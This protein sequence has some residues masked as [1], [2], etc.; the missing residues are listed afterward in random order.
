MLRLADITF[1]ANAEYADSTAMITAQQTSYIYLTQFRKTAE[2]RVIKHY[3]NSNFIIHTHKEFHFFKAN[4]RFGYFSFKALRYIKKIDADIILVE[5]LVFPLQVILLK[6]ALGRNVK[7]IA[8]HQ[9]ERPFKGIKKLLQVVADQCMNAYLFTSLGNAREWFEAGIIDDHSKIYE[10]PATL[11]GFSRL[12]KMQSRKKLN[13]GDG[14]QYLW[15]GRLN[16]NKDPLTVLLAFEQLLRANKEARLH[17][18]FQTEELLPDIRKK[19]V[20]SRYLSYAVILHGYM[21]YDQ[22]PVWYSAADF[23][24]SAS[25]LEGGCTAV[26]EAMAC[27]CV[28]IVSNIPASLKMIDNGACGLYF[29]TGDPISLH[30]QLLLAASL[31]Y[32]AFSQKVESHF[33][34]MYSPE[35]IANQMMSLCR[36]LLA[37]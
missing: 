29:T 6:M 35:A 32:M 26:L 33:I 34:K 7:L 17:M 20:A 27:G 10:I 30:D 19:I 4:N 13:M 21:A 24:I 1:F 22:L 15:V 31:P 9:A 36:K 5:G 37:K 8:K 12:D 16:S 11:T 3:T 18:I 28:P 25:H 14:P 2:V 23:Y